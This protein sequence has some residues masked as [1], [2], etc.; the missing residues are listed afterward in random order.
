MFY[1]AITKGFYSTEIHGD[2]IPSDS[3]EISETEWESLIKSQESGK[4]I[5]PDENGYPISV[6]PEPVTLP[7]QTSEEKLKSVGLSIDDLKTLLG[8]K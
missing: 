4:I 2:N 7:E 6:T 1:S 8:I 3:V 5:V